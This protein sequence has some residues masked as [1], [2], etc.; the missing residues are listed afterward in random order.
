MARPPTHR[1]WAITRALTA[2]LLAV[3]LL[4]WSHPPRTDPLRLAIGTGGAGG[5]YHV[6]GAGLAR[7]TGPDPDTHITA[8]TT[9]ASVENNRLVA[10]GSLDVAFSLADVASLAVKGEGP[11]ERPLPITAIARLYDNHTHVVVRADSPYERVA[12]LAGGTVSVGAMGSGTEM[13]A[14]RLLSAA[15]LEE[16]PR[17]A[18]SA[19]SLDE[20]PLRDLDDPE[21]PDTSDPS[22]VTRLRLS[23]GSSATALEEGRIDAF[24]WSG[25]LPTQA[26]SD[27]AARFPIR[28]LDLSEHVPSLVEDYGEFY[29]ELPVPAGTYEDVPTVRTIGVPSLLV[30]G[31]QMPDRTAE[32]F[33]RILFES[34]N[35]LVEIHPVALHLHPRSAIATL[36]VPLHPG[37]TTY[38]RSVKYAFDEPRLRLSPSPASPGPARRSS[39]GGSVRRCRAAAPDAGSGPP[40]GAPAG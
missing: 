7:V 37:A 26:V 11:F 36:P 2:C 19:P 34:Q 5:V 32:E 21:D 12:D 15:G 25:G 33:T 22:D 39:A 1:M 35:A 29:S 23:I 27:L 18:P 10:S 24:F 40:P 38:Y 20:E 17:T 3:S 8:L 13:M 30:A 14:E 9:A 28:L 4:S 6:Y 16:G 31:S